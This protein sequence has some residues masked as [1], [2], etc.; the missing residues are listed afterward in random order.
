V[1]TKLALLIATIAILIVSLVQPVYP[2]EQTLQ[3]VPTLVGLSLLALDVRRGLL[4]RGAFACCCM[5][6]WLHIVGARYIY[7]YVPYDAWLRAVCGNSPSEWFGWTRNHY[8]RLV[9]FGFG[10]MAMLPLSQG[11]RRATGVG[12]T[13]AV[14]FA[15]TAVAACSGIYEVL[16]W[17]LTVIVSP[18]DAE[19]YNG[20]QGDVWD[21]QKDMALAMLGAV[22]A[23]P[24]TRRLLSPRR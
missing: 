20:Q 11:V 16:E 10:A 7:S 24:F 6:L 14:L 12:R 4:S 9:H 13:S 15:L 17:L 2:R 3:H 18:V 23:A 8:D 5:F 21:P 19:S 22:V 1:R